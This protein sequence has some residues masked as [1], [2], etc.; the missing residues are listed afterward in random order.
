MFAGNAGFHSAACG[1]HPA[2]RLIVRPKHGEIPAR[3]RASAEFCQL[4]LATAPFGRSGDRVGTRASRRAPP[5][6]RARLVD[7][8]RHIRGA[9]GLERRWTYRGPALG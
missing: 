7:R 9:A 2:R 3:V 4:L 1:T 5:L 8:P 6:P